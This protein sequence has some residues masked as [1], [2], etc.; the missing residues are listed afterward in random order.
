MDEIRDVFLGSR[1][2]VYNTLQTAYDNV[3]NTH[4]HGRF[5]VPDAPRPPANF[6]VAAEGATVKITWSD[7][8]R[9]DPDFDTKEKDFAGYRV[10][11]AIGARD[12]VYHEIYDGTGNEVIDTDVAQ[13]Y[14]YF[15]YVV[16]YDD[17][18]Q[19]WEDPGVSL[20]SSKY[21]TWTGWAPT[22]VSPLTPGITAEGDLDN[23]RVVPNPYS[24]AGF[25]FPGEPD[26]ILF[27]GLP[28]QCTI[29]IYTTNG[30]Y[31]HKI[32]H[33]DGS[34]NEPWDLRTEFNQYIVSDVYIYTVESDL[35]D[36]VGKFII[37]R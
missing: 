9:E 23:I 1:D 8:S 14:Q 3:N 19:N 20:E 30:D 13:G 32:E 17:G 11:K 26:K 22:G 5:N 29:T 24:A 37:I 6:W 12:S 28:A 31:V 18:T 25:T 27:T 34:N 4:G 15:Y 2:S 33:T 16:A 7:E 10:Y 36:Q 35:G 21:H